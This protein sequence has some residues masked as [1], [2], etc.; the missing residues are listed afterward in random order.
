MD[1][2][3]EGTEPIR[4]LGIVGEPGIARL[5][6]ERLESRG[7]IVAIACDGQE[8]LAMCAASRYDVVVVDQNTPA[9]D[10]L[11]V[12]RC[13]ATGGQLPP[14]IIAVGEREEQ[15]VLKA[16]EL[17]VDDYVFKDAE[18]KHLDLLPAVI[19]QVLR[20]YQLAESKRKADQAVR[21]RSLYLEAAHAELDAVYNALANDLKGI[22]SV[23]VGYG[24]LLAQESEGLQHGALHDWARTS[25]K[26]GHQAVNLVD[27]L[28]VLDT[29]RRIDKVAREPLDT[30]VIIDHVLLR[31]APLISERRAEI[32]LP[33]EWPKAVGY[34]PWVQEVW[35]RLVS[36]AI[37]YGGQ[38]GREVP[39]RVELGAEHVDGSE[40]ESGKPTTRFWV[41]TSGPALP[42]KQRDLLFVEFTRR[43][44][45]RIEGHGLGLSIVR[46]IV[47]K[48]GGQAG[49]SATADQGCLFYFALPSVFSQETEVPRAAWRGPLSAR[50]PVSVTSDMAALPPDLLERLEQAC[51]RIDTSLV[52][53]LIDEVRLQ[54]GSL[55]GAL[56]ELANAFEFGRIVSAI[57]EVH[58]E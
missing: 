33:Q 2:T 30:S 9:H 58:H 23:L 47:D 11:E 32:V 17:G 4:V 40:S 43:S 55:A 10:G 18:G 26:T 27:E 5:M 50:P 45:L 54:N 31:L 29:V 13:L 38:P 48:L 44:Q 19:Q 1:Y 20:Q 15:I 16:L 8:G 35:A 37:E 21:G 57:R 46:R 41:R 6:Q 34:A 56:A 49:V 25:V 42:P 3:T 51:A 12:I 36:H 53:A 52:N 24:E 28:L 22:L 7:Y 14:S 39:P